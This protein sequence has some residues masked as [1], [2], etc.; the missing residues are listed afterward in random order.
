[1]RLDGP[2]YLEAGRAFSI[3]I[4]TSPRTPIFEDQSL[5]LECI[6]ILMDLREMLDSAV[7]AYCLMPD[8]VHLLLGANSNSSI[9]DVVGRWK[10]LCYRARRQRGYPQPFWQRG[11]FD[12]AL[13]REEDVSQAALYI[14]LNP[15]RKGLVS[16]FHQYPLCG[17]LEWEL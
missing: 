7:Y 6:Q 17:S 5:G 10:S 15:V 12:R 8:H 2:V 11:F 14:L 13:R 9:S 3:T 4:G 16:D 1:V